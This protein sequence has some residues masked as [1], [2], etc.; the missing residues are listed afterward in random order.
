MSQLSFRGC[1]LVQSGKSRTGILAEGCD[2]PQAVTELVGLTEGQGR[3]SLS[4]LPLSAETS[5]TPDNK[6]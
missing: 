2:G 6:S 4:T 5:V 1:A 3:R